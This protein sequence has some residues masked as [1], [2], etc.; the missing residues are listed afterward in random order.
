M[1]EAKRKLLVGQKG[2][3]ALDTLL[4][5]AESMLSGIRRQPSPR[6]GNCHSSLNFSK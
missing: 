6:S 2:A 1:G 4:L 3:I 5:V